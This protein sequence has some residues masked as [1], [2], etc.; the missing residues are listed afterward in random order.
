[1]IVN[2]QL[3]FTTPPES[4]RSSEYCTDIAKSVQAPIFHVNGDDPEACVR[5]AR[6]AYAYRQAFHKDVVVDMVCYRRH[7][8][9]ESDDPSYT[10]P[11]MYK[12]IDARRS[13]RKIYTESLVKR[14]DIS[15]EQAEAALDDF[16]ARLQTALDETRS[17]VA[18]GP[19]GIPDPMHLG[20]LPHVDTGVA[21]AVLDEVL[22][23]LDA[24]PEGFTVH[25]KLAKQFENR[26]RMVDGDGEVDWALGEALAIGSLIHEGTSVRLAGEDTR[27]G[28]FSHR[29]GV[30]VDF[31]NGAEHVPL[32]ALARDNAR[33]WLYDSLLSE[34]AA[35]GFEYGYSVQNKDVLVVWEAQFGDFMNGAQPIIDQFIVAAEDKWDQT[36]G[37][38]MLLP[39]GYEGQGPE[40]SS[41]RIERFLAAAAEDNIQICNATTA[42]QFFHLLRRQMRRNIRKPLVVFTPKSLLRAK[43]ARS[44]ID[45]FTRG[46]F[47]EVLDDAGVGDPAAVRRV[48]F[49]AGKIAVEAQAA[50][51]KA[52]VEVAIARVEQLY[53]W[54]EQ[55]VTDVLA[56]Y[57]NARQLFWLQE[58]PENMGAWNSIKGNLFRA[59]EGTHEIVQVSRLESASTAT[60]VLTMHQQEQQALFDAILGDLPT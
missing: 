30:L 57:P 40:H 10:Q 51:D 35:L 49:A 29:H 34:F 18:P 53:P 14:G 26:R 4:A 22:D 44:P 31:E 7:G 11:I 5:V 33:F 36:S 8:H 45:A 59:H 27:R 42:A 2:N 32:R 9:N 23:A 38:V 41:G 52:G 54:P 46:S 13:V 24:T 6:L 25:P 56:R 55:C 28:T 48:V 3:G 58:E 15:L 37:L 50:R 20:V 19:V 17:Q 12:R 39:H 16:R 21:R 43:A 60:G 47:E 1:V